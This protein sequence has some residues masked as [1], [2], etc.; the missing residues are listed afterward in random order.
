MGSVGIEV[1][2][3]IVFT[4]AGGVFSLGG[5]KATGCDRGIEEVGGYEGGPRGAILVY[6]A[7]S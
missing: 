1:S 7:A 3:I 6:T 5:S 4:V 2:S